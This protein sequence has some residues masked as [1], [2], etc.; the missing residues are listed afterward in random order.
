MCRNAT[1]VAQEQL[2]VA[3]DTK[4][5]DGGESITTDCGVNYQLHGEMQQKLHKSHS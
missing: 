5:V 1:E 2:L 3:V 4:L